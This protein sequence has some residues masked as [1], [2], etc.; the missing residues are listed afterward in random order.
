MIPSQC[1][2]EMSNEYKCFIFKSYRFMRPKISFQS[3]NLQCSFFWYM[4][5]K[6]GV[7][8]DERQLTFC[9]TPN[10]IKD[11][12]LL[13]TTFSPH[14]SPLPP[15]PLKLQAWR[16]TWLLLYLEHVIVDPRRKISRQGVWSC[17]ELVLLKSAPLMYFNNFF[18]ILFLHS[19]RNSICL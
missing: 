6:A 7:W 11:C 18:R 15:P 2:W 3:V 9:R 19:R 14:L 5:R 10:T 4:W 12:S 17:R 8:R 13:S 1:R 16:V